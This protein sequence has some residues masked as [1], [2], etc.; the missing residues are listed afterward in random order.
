M[1]AYALRKVLLLAVFVFQIV[2]GSPCCCLSRL[3]VSSLDFRLNSTVS[4]VTP[5]REPACPKCSQRLAES[6]QGISNCDVSNRPKGRAGISG[7]ENCNCVR[8]LLVRNPEEK[9]NRDSLDQRVY[10]LYD[11]H[12]P[13]SEL[14]W[15]LAIQKNVKCS[16]SPPR[17]QGPANR[18]WHC[19]ACIWIV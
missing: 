15:L 14:C 9:L 5:A 18:Y 8:N 7:N 11:L 2:G 13:L 3:V 17:C 10:L 6:S 12:K 1:Q 16:Y 4:R 19:I